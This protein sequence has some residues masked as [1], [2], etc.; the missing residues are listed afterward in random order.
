VKVLFVYKFLTMGGVETVLKVRLEGLPDFGIDAHAWFLFDGPGRVIFEGMGSR[1]HVGSTAMLR[2]FLIE[3]QFDLVSSLDTEEIFPVFKRLREQP[4]LVIEAHSPYPENL[5]YLR[6]V[7]DLPITAYFVPSKYQAG[8][9]E[10]KLAGEGQ[11]YVIPNP[12]SV[13]FEAD[14]LD[15]KPAPPYPVI[16]WIGRLD[17]LKNWKEF[18]DI[19]GILRKHSEKLEFWIVGR[20]GGQE[21]SQDVYKHAQRSGILD[22]LRWY[23]GLPYAHMP[24]LLDAVRASGG[25]VVSTSKGDSFGM[26]VAEAMARACA[27]VVPSEGPFSGFM[28]DGIHGYVYG[29]GKA[30]DGASKIKLLLGEDEHRLSFGLKGREDI[31]KQYAAGVALG[32]LANRLMSL[33]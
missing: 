27:V 26:T 1:V 4:V 5:E 29:L 21:I 17:E 22:R 7:G 18:V 13:D 8:V 15:F 31:M 11:I 28:K 30:G 32:A 2:D 14:L 6:L 16:A 33:M 9:I 24:T 12:L 25:V 10:R 3:E 23:R 20:S 19:A